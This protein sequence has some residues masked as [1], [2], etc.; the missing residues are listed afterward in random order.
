MIYRRIHDAAEALDR[1]RLGLNLRNDCGSAFRLL[2]RAQ[3]SVFRLDGSHLLHPFG[4]C[5]RG[6]GFHRFDFSFFPSYDVVEDVAGHHN[7]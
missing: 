3:E 6:V 4:H 5:W 7:S 2:D 1:G